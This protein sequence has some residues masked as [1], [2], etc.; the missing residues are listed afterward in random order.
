MKLINLLI[1]ELD[2]YTMQKYVNMIALLYKLISKEHV[3]VIMEFP[4][5]VQVK[6]IYYSNTSTVHFPCIVAWVSLSPVELWKRIRKEVKNH[7]G[8]EIDW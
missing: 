6:N 8:Y 1:R 4:D 7:F 5:W 3:I 2:S